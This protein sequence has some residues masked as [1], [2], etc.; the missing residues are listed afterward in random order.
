MVLCAPYD[1]DWNYVPIET[2]YHILQK[3][4]DKVSM[5]YQRIIHHLHRLSLHRQSPNQNHFHVVRGDSIPF[6]V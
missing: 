3:D 5:F 1:V 4:S 2:L 6:D